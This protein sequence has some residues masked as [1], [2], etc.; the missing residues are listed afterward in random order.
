MVVDDGEL[1]LN[2]RDNCESA[3]VCGGGEEATDE[4]ELLGISFDPSVNVELVIVP[5]V[6]VGVGSIDICA[7]TG[8]SRTSF[9]RLWLVAIANS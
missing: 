5:F 2:L 1:R 6:A 7:V 9:C 8:A 3:V 4:T